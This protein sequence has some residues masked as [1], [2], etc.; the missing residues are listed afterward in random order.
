MSRRGGYLR[1][2]RGIDPAGMSIKAVLAHVAEHPEQLDGVLAA[3]Q[4]GKARRSLISDL[5]EM[6]EARDA[7]AVEQEAEP[8]EAEPVEVEPTTEPTTEPEP[9]EPTEPAVEPVE[10]PAGEPLPE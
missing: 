1:R 2:K 8:V 6:V 3:E 10:S 5:S 7:A 9:T 4:A